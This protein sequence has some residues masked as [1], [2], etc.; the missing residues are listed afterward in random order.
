MWDCAKK[1]CS[2]TCDVSGDPHIK[3]FD[4][5]RYDM[6]GKCSYVLVDHCH[7]GAAHKEF[8]VVVRNSECSNSL[9]TS[10]VR[11][12]M[13]NL[14]T[15]NARIELGSVK[16]GNTRFPTLRVNGEEKRYVDNE[17]YQIDFVGDSNVIFMY[18]KK[19]FKIHWTGHNVYVTVGYQFENQ[20]CGLCGTY[21]FN[22]ADDF[23]TRSDSTETSVSAFTQSWIYKDKDVSQDLS[24]CHSTTWETS[25]QPCQI[26]SAKAGT[27]ETN[28][29]LIKDP[30]GPF[31][32][33]HSTVPP[34]EHF[35]M[36]K[37][38]ACKCGKCYCEVVAAYAKLCM[39]NGIII[40]GWRMKTEDCRKCCNFLTLFW[41]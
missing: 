5:K 37:Q 34:A 40:D 36:C 25:E 22:S 28:C 4:G 29:L 7:Y 17:N 2:A 15:L 27:A 20:T 39:D 6:Y 26:Y 13:V 18:K 41:L 1:P 3:T 21:N 32:A 23:H 33:C 38:D 10:C 14:P 19:Q 12:M 31:A 30:L 9:Y 35:S 11:N 24:T 8:E 16:K